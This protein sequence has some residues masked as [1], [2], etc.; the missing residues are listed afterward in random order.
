MKSRHFA[1]IEQTGPLAGLLLVQKVRVPV[2]A[3]GGE[4]SGPPRMLTLLLRAENCDH[5]QMF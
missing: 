5:T 2:V 1:C 4:G 3:L